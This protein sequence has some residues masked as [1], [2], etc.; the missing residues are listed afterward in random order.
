M[1]N[2]LYYIGYIFARLI[3]LIIALIYAVFP[4]ADEMQSSR[5]Y[6]V[7]RVQKIGGV[8][9]D[10]SQSN[11]QS[12][13]TCVNDKTLRTKPV[14]KLSDFEEREK[15]CVSKTPRPSIH[16]GQRKLF[17]NELQFMT[18]Y[19]PNIVVYAGAAPSMHI[20][21]LH[22]LFPKTKF[23]L[24][25]PNEFCII[26]RKGVT[27]YDEPA[28]I[29][30]LQVGNDRKNYYKGKQM[31]MYQNKIVDKESVRRGDNVPFEGEICLCRPISLI[32][33]LFT[34]DIARK[35]SEFAAKTKQTV[36]FWSDIRTNI[37]S[38]GNPTELDI[39]VNSAQ[40]LTWVDI[41]KPTASMLKFRCPFLENTDPN[42][43]VPEYAQ[44][45]LDYCKEK[46]NV[47]FLADYKNREFRYIDGEV[48]IQP[49]PG[50]SSSESRLV[51]S[52]INIVSYDSIEYE[53]KFFYY[54]DKLRLQKYF[55]HKIDKKHCI[56]RCGDCALEA[57]IWSDYTKDV[58]PNMI[59]LGDY[60]GPHGRSLCCGKHG[61]LY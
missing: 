44:E 59:S 57:S 61:K 1:S 10:F 29:E 60:L 26:K 6:G 58:L 54:N 30:Y 43:T 15:Y 33:N 35:V 37:I 53:D 21:R 25:D 46:F 8:T 41:M 7:Q 16:I 56:D 23:L 50:E 52:E 32:E 24:V 4:Q 27:Q 12:S 40:Q 22:E 45:Y 13:G 11:S 3:L 28:G 14:I 5:V 39:Y 36:A 51:F 38:D 18:K 19:K 34:I 2:I 42:L 9:E 55:G 47:D 17:L 48:F 49:W 20:W 31:V